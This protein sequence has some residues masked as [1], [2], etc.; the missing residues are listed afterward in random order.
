VSDVIVFPLKCEALQQIAEYIEQLH[1]GQRFL[2][3][4]TRTYRKHVNKCD[5]KAIR[6]YVSYKYN[7]VMKV[8]H[9]T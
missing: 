3:T 6:L 7:F 4:L 5:V 9:C 8:L 1:L 2:S